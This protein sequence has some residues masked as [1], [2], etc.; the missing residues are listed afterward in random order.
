MRRERDGNG[1]NFDKMT[2]LPIE[3]EDS[4]LLMRMPSGWNQA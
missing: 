1:S 4:E 2:Q 3:A